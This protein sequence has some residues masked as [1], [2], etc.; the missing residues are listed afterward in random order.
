MSTKNSAFMIVV[1]APEVERQKNSP[2]RIQL[3]RR[4][5]KSKYTT[6]NSPLS[7]RPS[8]QKSA[9]SR[10]SAPTPATFR[11]N[12]ERQETGTLLHT[13]R[14]ALM[15][16]QP[17]IREKPQ[18]TLIKWSPVREKR[19]EYEHITKKPLLTTEESE[20]NRRLTIQEKS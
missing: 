4:P 5:Q 19:L 3:P 14:T 1:D 16:L 15:C 9:W 12:R 10:H 17:V 18:V 13:Q 6:R 20:G 11:G 7:G 2:Q 8:A